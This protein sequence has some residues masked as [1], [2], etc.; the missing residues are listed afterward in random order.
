MTS[1]YLIYTKIRQERIALENLERQGFECFLP[2][3][4]V[5]KVR[6]GSMHVVE[7]PLFPRYLF[8]RLSTDWESQS[9]TPIRS[10][11]GVSRMVTFGLLPAKVDDALVSQL[12]ERTQTSDAI[13]RHFEPGQQVQVLEGPFA[14]VEAIFQMTDAE[15][16]VMVL[17]NMLSKEVKMTVSPASLR[18]MH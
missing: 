3:I 11:V 5:E 18:K 10:T 12:Q 14:G 16:R 9:W 8:V 17:L 2:K 4:K 6:R 1:W 15:G 7:E 13:L